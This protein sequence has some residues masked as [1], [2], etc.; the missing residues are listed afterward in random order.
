MTPET[1]ANCEAVL[2]GLG[3]RS[4]VLV[5][6]MGAGKSAIGR[7]VA[8]MLQLPFKDADTEIESAAQM[9]V[10]EIFEDYGEPEFRALEQRVIA[11]LLQSGPQVVATG[12]GAFMN[13]DTRAT[14][15]E[16]GVS[17]WLSA[18]LDLLMERVSRRQNRP[19][20]KTADPRGVMANLIRE[21]E[22]VYSMADV[23]VRSQDVPKEDMAARLIQSLAEWMDR[24]GGHDREKAFFNAA[25]A[26]QS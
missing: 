20:L 15:G 16:A 13:A 17:V 5:G 11:R 26:Q 24:E 7:K 21:R 8:A 25:G 2:A 19:L 12:G 6:L 10:A 4:I 9:T 14:I 3:N 18:D 1:T 22:P 23:E